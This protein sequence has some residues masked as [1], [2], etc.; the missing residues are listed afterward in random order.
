MDDDSQPSP[1]LPPCQPQVL[2]SRFQ[3]GREGQSY[4][5][6]TLVFSTDSLFAHTDRA[7]NNSMQ[8]E[9]Q[10]SQSAQVGGLSLA[11]ITTEH[12][13]G[14]SGMA[15]NQSEDWEKILITFTPLKTKVTIDMV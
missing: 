2:G 3:G 6:S 5:S 10:E 12:G 13:V 15:A 7:E 4:S 1:V 9:G 11:G 14:C 8:K